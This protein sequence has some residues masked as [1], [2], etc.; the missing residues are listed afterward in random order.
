VELTRVANAAA[1]DE[2]VL[3]RLLGPR[4]SETF[5]R[6]HFSRAP[7]LVKGAA[8]WLCEHATLDTCRRLAANP[9][10]EL[11][12]AREGEPFEGRRPTPDEARHLFDAG[13]TWALRNVDRGDA[14]LAEIGRTLAS[15]IHGTLHLQLYR[16]PRG[17]FGF[18]WHC[19]CEEVFVVQTV[20]RKRFRL[21]QNTLHPWPLAREQPTR[22]SVESEP[23][24]IE[25][26]VL[27]PGDCLYIPSGYWQV[28]QPEEEGIT[29]AFGVLAP[30]PLDALALVSAELAR[31]P[32]W[33]KRLPA[34]GRA[35]PMTEGERQA[36][37]RACLVELSK[38][39][40][41]R[42]ISRDLPVRLFAHTGWWRRR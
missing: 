34:I 14:T 41:A 17:P 22:L 1:V 25:E 29:A 2:G 18:G 27:A 19:D 39:L 38:E 40:D 9:D 31:D 4:S 5:F 36:A 20:G 24:P 26:H 33:R 28:A 3:E 42:L 10:V 30:S 16:S 13:Y 8:A 12:L 15:E 35:T 6:D 32:K 7:L 21:R 23:S 11:L 37:W